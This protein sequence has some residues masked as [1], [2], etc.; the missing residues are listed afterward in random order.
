M[1]RDR[2]WPL[3][4]IEY[5]LVE[6]NGEILHDKANGRLRSGSEMIEIEMNIGVEWKLAMEIWNRTCLVYH[7]DLWS[8][9]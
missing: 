2:S 3:V 7:R 5:G 9:S 4:E 8:S 1:C 6:W